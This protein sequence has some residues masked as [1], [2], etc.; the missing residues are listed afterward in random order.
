MKIHKDNFEKLELRGVYLIRNIDNGLL[1]IGKTNN[2]KRRYNQIYGSF[3]FCGY[4]PNLTVECFVEYERETELEKFLHDKFNNVRK[5]N[6]WFEINSVDD[7]VAILDEFQKIYTNDNKSDKNN[8]NARNKKPN[9]QFG[10]RYVEL[11]VMSDKFKH[12]RVI[13][14]T[15]KIDYSNELH[16]A[17]RKA[18]LSMDYDNTLMHIGNINNNIDDIEFYLNELDTNCII[19][20]DSDNVKCYYSEIMKDIVKKYTKDIKEIS[21]YLQMDGIYCDEDSVIYSIIHG[22]LSMSDVKS[23]WRKL[24]S[25]RLIYDEK[26]ELGV[27]QLYEHGVY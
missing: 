21:E 26:I 20:D 25:I 1:K 11:C 15:N 13:Y 23:H 12:Q 19:I 4:I 16:E 5:Q 27:T 24:H 7:V 14:K 22:E 2:F 17:I 6:E 9:E 3:K 18:T 8:V 10:Y